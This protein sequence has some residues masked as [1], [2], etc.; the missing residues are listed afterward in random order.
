[1]KNF[2]KRIANFIVGYLRLDLQLHFLWSFVLTLFAVIWWPM[3]YSGLIATIVKEA[4]DWWS[5]GKWSWDDFWFGLAGW[6]LALYLVYEY[7]GALPVY[8]W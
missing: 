6:L 2:Y 7:Q 5:K 1:M 3:L 4:L 8:V